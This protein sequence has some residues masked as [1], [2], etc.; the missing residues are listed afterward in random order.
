MENFLI[1]KSLTVTMVSVSASNNNITFT[2][3]YMNHNTMDSNRTEPV[4]TTT[5]SSSSN[6]EQQG[7]QSITLRSNDFKRYSFLSIF[8]PK[9]Q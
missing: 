7:Y 3:Y 4:T 2:L 5:S 6:N 8:P 9:H 1:L